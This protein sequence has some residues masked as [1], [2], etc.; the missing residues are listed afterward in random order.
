M[1]FMVLPDGRDIAAEPGGPNF[2]WNLDGTPE[3]REARSE[4]IAGGVKEA[5]KRS[6][7]AKTK[8]PMTIAFNSCSLGLKNPNRKQNAATHTADVLGVN[9]IGYKEGVSIDKLGVVVGDRYPTEPL[10]EKQKTWKRPGRVVIQ[11][12]AKKR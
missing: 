2:G 5:M 10:T 9:V 3:E 8:K 1:D 11:P 4:A 12:E 6:Q 7:V